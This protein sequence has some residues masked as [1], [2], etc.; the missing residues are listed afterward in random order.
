MVTGRI[1]DEEKYENKIGQVFE[2][3]NYQTQRGCRK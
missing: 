3:K 1:I 2:G